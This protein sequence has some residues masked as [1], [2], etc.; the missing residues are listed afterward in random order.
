MKKIYYIILSVLITIL[1]MFILTGCNIS[2]DS[3]D[4]T[5]NSSVSL[6]KA[7]IYYLDVGQGDSELIRLPTGEN[8]LIDAGLKSGSDQLTAYLKELGVDKIDILIATHPHAD[9]IGGMEKVIENF[10][11]GEIYMPKIADD[12]IPTTATYTKLLEAIQAKGMKINQAKAGT[13]IFSNDNAAL[14]I[15]APNNTEYKDLNNYS[16]VTKLTY[17]NN[18]FLFTGDAEKESENEMLSKG[19]D[20]SCD[21]LK[22]GHHGSS[23]S[24]TNQ[25][26]T[27]ASPSAAIISCGKDNDYGHPHQETMDKINSSHITV[28]RTDL[29]G[30]ILA[31]TDGTTYTITTNLK[32]VSKSS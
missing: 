19:Y 14:E 8:I 10:E 20:L 17:G 26:L 23:T 13:T 29:D 1:G 7:Q 11:I 9:H 30:T 3:S 2:I 21:I 28:Y 25:F 27:A 15:L 24:T 12:Q 18:R 6:D 32:S 4:N 31:E 22:L 16:I 5:T